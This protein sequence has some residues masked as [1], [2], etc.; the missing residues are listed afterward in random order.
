VLCSEFRLVQP[1]SQ[2]LCLLDHPVLEYVN[3]PRP[4]SQ[5]E[6]CPVH[7]SNNVAFDNVAGVN[8]AGRQCWARTVRLS[9]PWTAMVRHGCL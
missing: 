3:L 2:W 4:T 8:G 5:T 9:R 7:T 1:T 6:L